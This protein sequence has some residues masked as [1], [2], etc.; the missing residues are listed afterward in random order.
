[1]ANQ[2]L[3]TIRKQLREGLSPKERRGLMHDRFILL[4]RH[5]ALTEMDKITLDLWTKNHP[6]LGTAYDLKESYLDIWDCDSRQ[7]AF[8]KYNEWKAKIPTELQSA[9]E[10]LTKAMKNWE[11]EI[12]AYFDHRITNAYTESL[13][14][15]IRVINHL[16]R[17]Y[18]FEAL[19]AKILFTE[20]L[21][22]Q[23][24]PKYQRRFDSYDLREENFPMVNMPPIGV[25]REPEEII[26]LGIDFSTLIE[27]L[28]KGQL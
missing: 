18:S 22:K 10:P 15:L 14:S 2:A 26:L 27:K 17:G 8:L 1:M 19:R 25:V 20:G 3:E 23:R 11:E 6:S 28:E 16:G 4:K 13:N 21:K 9:F 7:T 24:K 5:I 12:F